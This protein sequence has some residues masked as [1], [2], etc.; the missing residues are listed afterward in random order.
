[1][2]V[3]LI[4]NRYRSSSPS[5]EDHVVDQESAALAADGHTV[6]HFERR[7]DD[8]GNASLLRRAMVP[9]QVLWSEEARRSLARVLRIFRPDV[10]HVH[11]TFPLL[12]P[13]VLYAG[14]AE[15]V[16]LVATLHQYRL[17]CP[18]GDLFRDG[19]VCHDCVGRVPLP[20]VRHGC[21]RDSSAA[22]LPVA[23]SVIS[24]RRTWRRLVSAYIFLS[25]AQC[26]LFPPGMFPSHRIFIKPNFVPDVSSRADRRDDIVVYAGRLTDTKGLDVLMTAWDLYSRGPTSGLRLQLA[27]AGPMEAEVAAWAAAHPTVDCLGA[28]SRSDCASL[29]ARARAV[30]VPSR[31]EETFGLV[32]VEAMAAG[33]APVASARGSFCELITDRSDG[34]LFEPESATAL[35]DVLRE[36]LERPEEYEKYGR[37]ARRTYEERFSPQG[38]VKQLLRIYEFA[39]RNPAH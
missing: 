27:G 24:H 12:S 36:V 31:W 38:N 22:T 3:L 8:I 26:D 9:A 35:A 16:P 28:L 25:R 19:G 4:H 5:G 18:R 33:V 13:S 32:A 21:Y 7:S 6:E 39:V 34:V 2:R 15:G 14:R 37:V 23:A 10:A 20:A 30:I 17:I 1:M 29:I 11:N